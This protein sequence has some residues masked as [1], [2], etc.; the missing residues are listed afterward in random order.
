MSDAPADCLFCRIAR[1]EIESKVVFE[2]EDC[3]A[4]RDINPQAPTHVL[5]IPKRHVTVTDDLAP[6][7]D[8]L[9]GKLVRMGVEVAKREG[10]AGGT[11]ERGYRLVFNAGPDS[12]YAVFHIHLHV[13]GGRRMS[14]PPG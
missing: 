13:L 7:D 14:W 3:L 1:K 2:D 11:R 10:L 8:S 5:V 12:G 9:I 6:A 4:F